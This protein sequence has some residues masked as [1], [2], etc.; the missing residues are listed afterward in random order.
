VL[1]PELEVLDVLRRHRRDRDRRAREVDALVVR[2]RAAHLDAAL[3]FFSGD[4]DHLQADGPVVDQ[5]RISD[6]H[7]FRQPFV[8][9]G[10]PLGVADHSG[11]DGDRRLGPGF[12]PRLAALDLAHA[13]LGSLE[14]EQQRYRPPG[15]PGGL[16]HCDDGA[17]VIVVRSVREVEPRDVHSGFDQPAQGRLFAGGRPHG[18]D[19]LRLAHAWAGA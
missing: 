14:I 11:V 17:R 1:E 6:R 13:D 10:E 8:G 15:V 7:V 5:D 4:R 16:A 19:D 12:D 18:A 9:A 2:E 3:H